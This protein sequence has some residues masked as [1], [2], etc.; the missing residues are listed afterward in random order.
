MANE[1]VS[2]ALGEKFSFL[3][4]NTSGATVLIALLAAFYDTLSIAL[5]E[6]VPN[7][8]VLGYKNPAA[9]T[10]AGHACNAVLDDGTILP[11][12][13]CTAISNKNSIRQFREYVKENPWILID[14]TIQATTPDQFNQI[15]EVVKCSPLTGNVSQELNLNDFK[16]VDQI[17]TDKV[18]I[19]NLN[20]EMADFNNVAWARSSVLF[21]K[22]SGLIDPRIG[23]G[24]VS[25]FHARY[26]LLRFPIDLFF[27]STDIFIVEFKTLKHIGSDHLPLYC[28]FYINPES[29]SQDNH[30]ETLVEDE[31]AEVNELIEAGKEAESERPA[32]AMEE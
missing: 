5:T 26:K 4:K 2:K 8:A 7:T 30:I 22:T 25:T 29:T 14:M 16:S 6:G 3:I 15:I 10:A 28:R 17:S 11:G 1:R 24:F 12:V 27:H 21:R 9:I 23:R 31:M 13:L 18:N 32:L 20:L 19:N